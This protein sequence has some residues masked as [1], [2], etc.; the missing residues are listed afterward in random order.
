MSALHIGR[1]KSIFFSEKRFKILK[2]ILSMSGNIHINRLLSSS[3]S[4]EYTPNKI[5]FM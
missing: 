1:N 4:S 3:S 2:L 5:I